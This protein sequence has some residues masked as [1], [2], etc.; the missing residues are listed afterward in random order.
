MCIQ[1]VWLSQFLRCAP[2]E[3]TV[4]QND[5]IILPPNPH[6]WSLILPGGPG[7]RHFAKLGPG[8]TNLNLAANTASLWATPLTISRPVHGNLVEYEFAVQN[9]NASGFNILIVE[10]LLTIPLAELVSMWQKQFPGGL[11]WPSAPA[12]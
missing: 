7:F 3:G 4:G 1:D 11:T 8:G 10:T 2:Y 9:A 5:I 12:R 6:R